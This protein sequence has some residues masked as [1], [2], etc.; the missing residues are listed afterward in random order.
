MDF[1]S[2]GTEP[3]EEP[4]EEGDES[5]EAHGEQPME[6]LLQAREE[7]EDEQTPSVPKQAPLVPKRARLV[8]I[9]TNKQTKRTRSKKPN[10]RGSGSRKRPAENEWIVGD[11]ETERADSAYWSRSDTGR[12]TFDEEVANLPRKRQRKQHTP[13]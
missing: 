4:G 12:T 8:H 13:K 11:R 5:G 9:Q 10:R 3:G 2:G 1:G 6:E 7:S